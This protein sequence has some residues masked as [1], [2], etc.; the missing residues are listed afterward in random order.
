MYE[1]I[2]FDLDGTISD[3]KIGITKSV[4][5]ALKYFD[6]HI[7]DPEE[8]TFFIGPP[9]KDNLME[10]YG[11]SEKE[12]TRA[13]EYFREY[14]RER[15]K[16]ENVLYPGMEETLKELKK[17]GRILAVATSKPTVFAEEIL[18]Y[19]KV[20]QYFSVIAGSN[21]DNTRTDKTE[22]VEY[23][24]KKLPES[25]RQ[26]TIMIGDR[27]HDIIGA[28]NNQIKS[29]G[30]LYGYG[31]KDELNKIKPDYIAASV[32]ELRDILIKE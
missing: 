2:L 25:D 26:N 18:D 7:S 9:L 8:L 28:K 23:V 32:E 13:I 16:F 15:G 24:L 10:T 21:L 12:T 6:I 3:P 1:T 22:V 31:G 17:R 27:K 30:V 14:F 11:F 4:Q 5:Y 19:F 29:I 20:S